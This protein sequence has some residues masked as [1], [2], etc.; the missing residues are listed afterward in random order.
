MMSEQCLPADQIHRQS[1]EASLVP[2]RRHPSAEAA[3]EVPVHRAG[4]AA[5][6]H[7][8]DLRAAGRKHRKEDLPAVPAEGD[9]KTGFEIREKQNP[10]LESR[11]SNRMLTRSHFFVSLWIVV[12]AGV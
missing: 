2:I 12:Q 11:I 6:D 9:S 3:N 8:A 1:G 4:P 10:Y 5:E 7:P